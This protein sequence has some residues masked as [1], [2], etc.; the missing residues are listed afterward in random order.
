MNPLDHSNFY[1]DNTNMYSLQNAFN[2][3][4]VPESMCTV[5]CFLT[6]SYISLSI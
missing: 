6:F 3:L 1:Q 4:S 5:P 2:S